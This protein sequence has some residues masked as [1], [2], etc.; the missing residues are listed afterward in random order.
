MQ[1]SLRQSRPRWAADPAQ[2]GTTITLAYA[3]LTA[4]F[5]HIRW[6]PVALLLVTVV[7]QRLGPRLKDLYSHLV[8]Y[9]MFVVAYDALRYGR[10][11]FLRADRVSHC[12]MRRL[13]EQLLSFGSGGT[14]GDWIQ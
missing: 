12:G 14:P 1:N 2:W 6:E 5:D 3:V 7:F 8:P 13:E 4:L 10:D 11:A 9:L